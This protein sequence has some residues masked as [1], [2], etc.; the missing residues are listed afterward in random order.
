MKKITIL[1]FILSFI[2]IVAQT[3]EDK[4][5]IT[6]DY[7][8][9]LIKKHISFFRSTELKEKEEARIY[10]IRNSL[11][12]S[13]VKDSVFYEL[14]KIHP[15]GFPIYY[16]TDNQNAAKTTR[17]NF[18]NTGGGLGLNVNGQNM[19]GRVW[20]GGKVRTTHNHFGNRVVAVDDQGTTY[21]SHATHVA[22]T[23]LADGAA[24]IRGMAYQGSG[25]TF[26]WTDDEAEVISET[27][28]GML[29]SNHSY[30]VLL[31]NTLPAWYIGTYDQDAK[32][33]DQIAYDAPYYLMVTSAGNSGDDNTSNA[34]AIAFGYDKLTANKTAK[35]NLVIANAQDAVID[36]NG[37]LV[38]VAINSSS[39]Q[40]PTDDRRI[41]P[42]ITGN[43]TGVLSTGSN[44]NTATA[45]LTGTS[46]ASPNVA[47]TLLLLQQHFKNV[48]NLFMKAATLKGLACH[49][50]DDAG[51]TGPDAVFGWGLLNAKAAAQA[52]SSN[53]LNS[54]ISEESLQQGGSKTY[55]VY[56]NGTSPLMASITWTDV[57][58][59]ANNS[60]YPANDLRRALVNDL[61]IRI[62]RNNTTFFPW[63]LNNDPTQESIRTGDNNVD[64]VEL[65]AID[66]PI[67][68]TYTITITHK[69]NL[70][71]G[72][73]DFS[74]IATGITSSFGLVPTSGDNLTICASQNATYTFNYVQ[75]GSGTAIFSATGLPSGVSATFT[76]S[77]LSVS[78][79]VSVTLSNFNSANPGLYNFSIVATKGSEVIQRGRALKLLST[80]F[81]LNT[82]TIP[83]NNQNILPTTVQLNWNTNLNA[84]EYRVQV[85]TSPNFTTFIVNTL[86]SQT[87]YLLTN[88]NENTLYYWRI[89]SKN[90]C[91]AESET[92]AIVFSFRTGILTCGVE[93]VATDFST[94][95]IASTANSNAVV[96]L[97]VPV[98]QNISG[99][100]NV[101]MT[102]NHT[103]VQDI[104]VTLEGPVELGSPQIVLLEHPCGDN[105]NISCTMDDSG[106]P[107]FCTTTLPSISGNVIPVNL[108]ANLNGLNLS[109]TWKLKVS[110][111]YNG[112][113]GAIT[114]FKLQVCNLTAPL[115][116]LNLT[117]TE[118][119][120]TIYPNPATDVLHIQTNFDSEFKSTFELYD[121]QGRLV[122]TKLMNSTTDTISV[123]HLSKGVYSCKI[124][125]DT[126]YQ[127]KKIIIQ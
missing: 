109:G 4:L 124:I 47:G 67:A 102:I 120:I 101:F 78:G 27:L 25:R 79:T 17:A 13:Y 54:I 106:V 5:I 91:G 50:A 92:S 123:N 112:D 121:M 72:K 60:Q 32:N 56:S 61:D 98:N 45:T 71:S 89:L 93:Y 51:V 107:V 38:S 80:S 18:L 69:G 77:S 42:D 30:G 43:G 75:T 90:R 122:L 49:T 111:P 125:N 10:A 11:P 70:V 99:D 63:R 104:K 7:N 48:T 82:L 37:N 105:D 53:G 44:S 33:W 65:V 64:N 74:F 26:D 31:A 39:S 73:Q 52:I 62:T 8:K 40:G 41:K 46:M 114:A 100:V 86:V 96:P 81:N 2:K 87:N 116:N 6:K 110:D 83:N 24:S 126:K 22:G 29:I 88:L 108:L 76:P 16:V 94:S 58:G 34:D 36:V 85:S 127:I 15:A 23:M 59:E 95:T 84:E 103:Y 35:N 115:S 117:A 28:D 118:D 21:S 3:D 68:G 57:P 20:D 55:T 12:I 19:V 113:G 9:D 66:N 14:Q 97:T 1:F 119:L